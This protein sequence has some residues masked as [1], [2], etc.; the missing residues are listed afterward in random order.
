[1][2]RILQAALAVSLL[3]GSSALAQ[4]DPPSPVHREL[5]DRE[6]AAPSAGE[7]NN[8]AV[9][10]E[11]T[12]S[13][14]LSE[15]AAPRRSEPAAGMAAANRRDSADGE[16]FAGLPG[17][18]QL[19][20]KKFSSVDGSTFAL[21]PVEGGLRREIVAPDGAVKRTLFV[22]LN[23][24]MGA[25]YEGDDSSSV[26]G[27][28]RITGTGVAA[29]YADGRSETLMLNGAGGVS[30]RLNA[31]T[32][33]ATCMAWYPEGHRFS[34]QER[35]AALAEYADRIGLHAPSGR[36]SG[37]AAKSSCVL[38]AAWTAP[39]PR[40]R[41][42]A[43]KPHSR[44]HANA[45][46]PSAATA[47][48]TAL[49]APDPN[50]PIVVRTSQVHLIDA[51]AN[52]PEETP[53]P[54]ATASNEPAATGANASA[55]LSVESDGRHWGFR[56]RC[57]YDVQ[58]AYCLMNAA[59]PLTSCREAAVSGSV[60]ANGFGTLIV[61]QGLH[62]TNADHDFRWIACGGGAGE[63]VAHLDRSDPPAGRC[64]RPGAS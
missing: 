27:V 1:M 2:N 7:R 12:V 14:D 15:E 47:N 25:V 17:I 51:D 63:V 33:A 32:G 28:F 26:V 16:S 36:N 22:F 23:D 24:K 29:D 55:C 39:V 13:P 49:S 61:D 46:A 19:A 10:G 11:E 35:K 31:P 18:D 58:F 9:V 54:K 5:S 40:L 59:D 21:A 45:A 57:A 34:T 50:E 60:A 44:G 38:A 48:L 53:D 62:D 42:P 52:A 64:L 8:L 4:S 43:P 3:G 20:D 30:M 37:A 41:A 6:P 56:N